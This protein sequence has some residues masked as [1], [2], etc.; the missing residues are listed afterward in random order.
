[1]PTK[2]SIIIPCYNSEETLH[3]T[4]HSVQEQD[5]QNWEAIIINDGSTDGTENIALNWVEKDT[6]FKY[7]SKSNEGLG[8]TRNYGITKAIGEYILPL[9]SDNLVEKDFAQKA[10]EILDSNSNIGV[11]H[12]HAEYFGE[13]SGVWN[14]NEYDL[15][16][17]LG[18]NYIDACA[19][20]RKILWA[21]VGGYEEKMPYQ[22]EEDW[23]LWIALGKI[24][25][26]FQHL[27]KVTFKYFV[28]SKS[29][30]RSFNNEM[31][32]QNRNFIIKKHSDL[33]YNFYKTLLN[34][35]YQN[36]INLKSEKFV[37]DL[38]FKTFFK[39]TIFGKYKK[40]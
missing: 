39:F 17:I 21:K 37:I 8:K 24:K 34:R 36:K 2:L 40:Q 6:R 28:N 22:G 27:H 20:Y 11:V 4:L 5:F 7:F 26:N 25:V 10:I 1:M 13:R 33:Y 19:I 12:G 18:G 29:M 3:G 14:I 35:Q 9:D 16:K 15:E 23:E 30:I 38:F 32:K 31:V